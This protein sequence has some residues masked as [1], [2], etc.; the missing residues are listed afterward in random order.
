MATQTFFS[1]LLWLLGKALY[2]S[3]KRENEPLI[4]GRL[5]GS[6]HWSNF[7]I[8]VEEEKW[9]KV[10]LQAQQSSRS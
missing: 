6:N 10:G 7:N 1:T 4:A 8:F 3:K 5:G 9:I 2:K